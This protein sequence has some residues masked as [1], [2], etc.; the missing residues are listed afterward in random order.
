M[1]GTG[2]IPQKQDKIWD[3]SSFETA[4]A[5]Y[6]ALMR[7]LMDILKISIKL[8]DNGV[9]TFFVDGGFAR[10]ALF[11][12]MLKSDFKDKTIKTLDVPQATAL[13]GV[14]RVKRNFSSV[15]EFKI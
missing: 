11:M 10:N 2:P 12:D 7:G 14:L 15:V 3:L 8:V 1:E 6:S 13:G 5:A 4:E 9:K